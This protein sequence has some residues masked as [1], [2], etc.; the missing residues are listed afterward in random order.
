VVLKDYQTL[1]E[2]CSKLSSDKLLVVLKHYKTWREM[3]SQLSSDKLKCVR[4]SFFAEC[5]RARAAFRAWCDACCRHP[6]RGACPRSKLEVVRAKTDSSLSSPGNASYATACARW[7]P[8]HAAGRGTSTLNEC[9]DSPSSPVTSCR[10]EKKIRG[11][12]KKFQKN[13]LLGV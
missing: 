8:T 6:P 10:Q 9:P 13:K 11:E 12:N 3:C 4:L 5:A 2:I 1:R 7:R